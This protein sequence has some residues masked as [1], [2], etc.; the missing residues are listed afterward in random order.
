[1]WNQRPAALALTEDPTT[2]SDGTY[3]N[4]KMEALVR[5]YQDNLKRKDIVADGND[6]A[7]L[8]TFKPQY[9]ILGIKENSMQ[10]NV[11]LVQNIGWGDYWQGGADGTFD[12]LAE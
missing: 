11:N 12:P 2:N 7:V 1:M 3:K 5:F 10:N 6:D 9:Y 8:P 4:A